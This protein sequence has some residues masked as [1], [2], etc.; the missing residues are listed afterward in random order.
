[1]KWN[2]LPILD[3]EAAINTVAT[4][5][6]IDMP[7]VEKDWWVTAVL[8]AL[9][10]T[11][12]APYL[13]FKGGTSLSKGWHLINRFSEDIDVSLGREWF[14]AQG[15]AYA[16]GANKSQ[17]ERLRKHARQVI[18]TQL[19][20]EL[21]QQLSIIGITDCEVVPII[22]QNKDGVAVP[23]D[24]DKDP[25]VLHV[26]YQSVIT[27]FKPDYILPIVKIE[28]SCLSL[29]EPY[30]AR[31]ITSML[32][33]TFSDL[34]NELTCV[35]NTVSPER[36]FL[37]KAF[38]LNEEFQKD[39]PRTNRM[40]RHFYDLEKL[41]D[42]AFGKKALADGTLYEHI[43]EHRRQFYNLHYVDYDKNRAE[44]I[45]FYP[46]RELM[47]AFRQDYL[48]MVDTFIFKEAPSFDVLMSRIKEL[49][50]RFRTKA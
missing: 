3:R 10:Q 7:S 36:T 38:L 9:F 50:E 25:T 27:D 26:R 17:R 34:D 19:A 40:S 14:A 46:S 44:N 4:R 43:I 37:E 2:E 13:L 20:D 15:C 28:I 16:A 21:K 18:T 23:I 12:F 1:M 41:M 47:D 32:H 24:S 22:S 29:A 45:Q 39:K 33:G 11:S 30:G 49:Q 35:V 8:S 42:T 5:Y 31:E 6:D 48:N